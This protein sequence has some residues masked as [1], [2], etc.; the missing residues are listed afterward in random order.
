MIAYDDV[1]TVLKEEAEEDTL[2][3][4]GVGDE[5][6]TDGVI[7]KTKRR[8]NWLLLNLFTAFIATYCISLFGATIE[9]MIVLAFLM[10]IVASMGGNAGMQT[11]AVTVRSFVASVLTVTA[12]VCMPALPPIDATIGIKKAKTTIC[13]IVAPNKLMQ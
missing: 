11:L 9:Q 12:K 3:L 7:T 4:A 2:R 1:L 5:E 10:P 8:F 6:I 13:S